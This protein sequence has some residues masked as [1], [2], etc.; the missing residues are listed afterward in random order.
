MYMTTE[1]ARGVMNY[2]REMAE[3]GCSQGQIAFSLGIYADKHHLP[4]SC[5]PSDWAVQVA[6]SVLRR[7]VP[8]AAVTQ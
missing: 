2:A 8:A 1:Q 5:A 6:A 4:L 3:A 7:F